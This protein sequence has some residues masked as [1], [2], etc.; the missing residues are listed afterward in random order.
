MSDPQ[1][2]FVWYELMTTDIP[3]AARFYGDVVGWRTRDWEGPTPYTLLTSGETTLGGAWPLTDELRAQGVPPHWLPYV[4]VRDVDATAA[5]ATRLGGGVV[6]PAQDIPNTGRFAVLRDPQGAAFAVYTPPDASVVRGDGTFAPRAGEFSW[7]ELMTSDAPAA[8]DFYRRLFGWEADSAFDMG[9]MG[10]YQLFG[11]RGTPYGGMFNTPRDVP[12][13]PHWLC[14]VR[15][16][17]LDAAVARV[18]QDGGQVLNGPME[19]PGGD[20]IAQCLDPQG[21]AFALHE[22]AGGRG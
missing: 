15:V 9:E 18:K 10:T 22:L 3:G 21:A 16:N 6:V 14:Y 17:D 20:R 5:E 13:P 8:F 12:A 11:Q 19:V 1:G 7:H 4:A 2:R